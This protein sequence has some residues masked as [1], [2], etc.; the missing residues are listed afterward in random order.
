MLAWIISV[1]ISTFAVWQKSNKSSKLDG[2]TKEKMVKIF[3]D[4]PN[5]K[6][7]DR[8]NWCEV[9]YR[10]AVQ[11]KNRWGSVGKGEVIGMTSLVNLAFHRHTICWAQKD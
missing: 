9:S 11:E 1:L 2:K 4:H 10:P 8:R 3:T 5:K 6:L 7:L